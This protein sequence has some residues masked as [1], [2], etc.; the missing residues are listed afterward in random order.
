[1][2]SQHDSFRINGGCA[3]SDCDVCRGLQ[4]L[5]DLAQARARI[6]ELESC[7]KGLDDRDK[8]H[9]KWNGK[10]LMRAEAAEA[11]AARYREALE[12]YRC[13]PIYENVSKV[14]TPLYEE[15]ADMADEALKED[16][17]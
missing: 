14:G 8:T 7:V 2:K 1:M 17:K 9:G 11:R 12:W 16:A 15:C 4:A 5:N 13:R 3:V 6:A 10:L